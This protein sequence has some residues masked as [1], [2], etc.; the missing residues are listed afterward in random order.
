MVYEKPYQ[1][2]LYVIKLY[3]PYFLQIV[4]PVLA[5]ILSFVVVVNNR[6]LKK[7]HSEKTAVRVTKFSTAM[8]ISGIVFPLGYL[9]WK[10]GSLLVAV[11]SLSEA[12]M[13]DPTTNSYIAKLVIQYFV[14]SIILSAV[15]LLIRV[16]SIQKEKLKVGKKK[17]IIDDYEKITGE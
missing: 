10:I 17:K 3:G 12:A 13:N 15:F 4:I 8:I 9:G 7:L 2:W 11:R 6:K 14:L 16:I 5:V 1:L